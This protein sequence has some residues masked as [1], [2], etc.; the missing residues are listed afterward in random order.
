MILDRAGA[1]CSKKLCLPEGVVLEYL[2]PYCPELNPAERFFQELR[3]EP[4]NKIFESL[5]E[6]EWT[7]T[8]LP[9]HYW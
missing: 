2:P 8:R 5:D 9:E 4:V 1:H 6:L 7:L 3:K